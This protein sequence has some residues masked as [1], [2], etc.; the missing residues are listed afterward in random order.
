MINKQ[1]NAG[2]PSEHHD[3]RLTPA[4]TVMRKWP[5]NTLTNLCT[6]S[7]YQQQ[8]KPNRANL[9]FP[10]LWANHQYL[11]LDQVSLTSRPT[12]A[13]RTQRGKTDLASG[14]FCSSSSSSSNRTVEVRAG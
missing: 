6:L 11:T 5:T 4:K 10:L 7:L 8:Q 1:A 2:T 14:A 13:I 12:K 9:R 3:L